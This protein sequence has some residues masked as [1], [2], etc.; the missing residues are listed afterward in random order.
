MFVLIIFGKLQDGA[1]ILSP[2]KAIF[3]D[4]CG[5]LIKKYNE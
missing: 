4:N 3:K 5:V 1:R 2:I